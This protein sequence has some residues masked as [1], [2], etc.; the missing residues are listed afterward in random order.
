[1]VRLPLPGTG[2][3]LPDHP[4]VVSQEAWLCG[5][6]PASRIIRVAY[7]TW[8][9]AAGR[10]HRRAARKAAGVALRQPGAPANAAARKASWPV[11][12]TGWAQRRPAAVVRS[13][14]CACCWVPVAQPAPNGL[15]LMLPYATTACTP[16]RSQKRCSELVARTFSPLRAGGRNAATANPLAPAA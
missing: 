4:A 2:A 10:G 14:D 11:S 7:P 6:I 8:P 13:R 12:K 5:L 16:D 9:P 1:M 15:L 3:L